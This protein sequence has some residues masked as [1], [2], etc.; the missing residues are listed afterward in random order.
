MGRLSCSIIKRLILKEALTLY[1]IAR[2]KLI[3]EL[4]TAHSEDQPAE[5]TQNSVKDKLQGLRLVR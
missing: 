5:E 4:Q 3:G 2:D 1:T